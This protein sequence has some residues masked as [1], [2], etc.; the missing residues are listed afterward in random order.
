MVGELGKSGGWGLF[1]FF[2]CRLFVVV[3]RW[4]RFFFFFCGVGVRAI[5]GDL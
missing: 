4:V 5:K 1:L 3:L 2:F